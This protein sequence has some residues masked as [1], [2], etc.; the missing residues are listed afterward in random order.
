MHPAKCSRP[1]RSRLDG[2]ALHS[3]SEI[4]RSRRLEPPRQRLNARLISPVTISGFGYLEAHCAVGD[5]DSILVRR[6]VFDAVSAANG[7]QLDLFRTD[8]RFGAKKC[9]IGNQPRTI[10]RSA[11]VCRAKNPTVWR[12]IL[13]VS[14]RRAGFV[15]SWLSRPVLTRHSDVPIV[16]YST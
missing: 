13:A 4:P 16:S 1:D 14:V 2:V 5:P 6:R 3:P 15:A 10:S 7:H 12:V 11:K 8:G 9:W